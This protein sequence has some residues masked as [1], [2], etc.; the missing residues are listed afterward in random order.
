MQQSLSL[1]PSLSHLCGKPA[2]KKANSFPPQFSIL[3]FAW[4]FSFKSNR[5]LR[6]IFWPKKYITAL[7]GWVRNVL[8]YRQNRVGLK[9]EEWNELSDVRSPSLLHHRLDGIVTFWI[10]PS[11]P[12]F[13]Q[14]ILLCERTCSGNEPAWE[15]G[16][17]SERFDKRRH[18][19][20]LI[21]SQYRLQWR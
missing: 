16:L 6:S 3:V 12:C 11:S 9:L 13:Q 7:F 19:E 8:W 5:L 18:W 1:T 2:S 4:F 10:E 21:R 17:S 14:H 15:E 20:H